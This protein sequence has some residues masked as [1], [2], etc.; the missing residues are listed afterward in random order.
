[1]KKAVIFNGST[2][3]DG[4]GSTILQ[5]IE[6]GLK[7]HNAQ[8]KV[9]NLFQ[10]KM[11]ACMGCFACR[12]DDKGKCV[13]EDELTAAIEELKTADIVV[14]DSPIFFMHMSGMV[15]NLYDRFYPL[16]ANDFSPR[17][18]TKKI[19]TVYTQGGA[20]PHMYESYFDYVSQC[21]LPSFGF[22]DEHRIVCPNAT[23]PETAEKSRELTTNAYELGRKLALEG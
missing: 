3:Y 12:L 19:V 1:M 11:S 17:F 2:R 22:V 23:N 16:I 4:N 15:K 8:V 10:L 13:I 18:G 5:F 14:I 20:D 6:R 7:E 21:I 9:Y